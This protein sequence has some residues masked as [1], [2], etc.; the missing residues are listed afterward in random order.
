MSL[1]CALKN[2]DDGKFCYIYF[3]TIKKIFNLQ[4]GLREQI[5][6]Q[7]PG[8]EQTLTGFGTSQH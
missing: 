6:F 4:P 3:A 5:R 1:H 2:G 7:R 8:Q